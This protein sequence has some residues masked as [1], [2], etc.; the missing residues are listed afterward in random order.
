MPK[1]KTTKTAAKRFKKTGTGQAP[2][3]AGDAPAPVRE[4][5]VDAH[6]PPRRRWSTCTPATPRRSSASS[7]SAEPTTDRPTTT[8]GDTTWHV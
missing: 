7:A 3:P 6:P 5:A 1:M 4:E 8:R 2:P